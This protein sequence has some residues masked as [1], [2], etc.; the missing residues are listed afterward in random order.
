MTQDMIIDRPGPCLL[1]MQ[2]LAPTVLKWVTLG[3]PTT[4]PWESK[5]HLSHESSLNS[6]SIWFRHGSFDTS[7]ACVDNLQGSPKNEIRGDEPP[8]NREVVPRYTAWLVD[9]VECYFF[10][11]FLSLG[12]RLPKTNIAPEGRP[13]EKET[14]IPTIHLQV[15]C[16]FQGG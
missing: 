4:F 2:D 8:G 11:W 16:K 6:P 13:S 1:S 12:V 3:D 5:K 15:L 9:W 7:S 10:V 14:N